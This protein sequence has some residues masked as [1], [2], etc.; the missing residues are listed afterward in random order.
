MLKECPKDCYIQE[1][2]ILPVSVFYRIKNLLKVCFFIFSGP[3]QSEVDKV[4][5][6]IMERFPFLHL[7][8]NLRVGQSSLDDILR[9]FT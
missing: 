8:K 6:K 2:L 5:T 1:R 4:L 7:K 9:A 3:I